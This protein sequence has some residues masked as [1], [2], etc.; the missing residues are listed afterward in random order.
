MWDE[1]GRGQQVNENGEK[2][3]VPGG[4]GARQ[5]LGGQRGRNPRNPEG[6][7]ECENRKME[8][9]KEMTQLLSKPIGQHGWR[10]KK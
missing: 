1:S 3:G 7:D 6:T 9:G 5:T 2:L 4:V 8:K 10:K